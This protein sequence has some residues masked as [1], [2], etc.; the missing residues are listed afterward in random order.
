MASLYGF[1]FKHYPTSKALYHRFLRIVGHGDE[2]L[3]VFNN[4]TFYT[5][6]IE[7]DELADEEHGSTSFLLGDIYVAEQEELTVYDLFKRPGLNIGGQLY[8][9][10]NAYICEFY[11]V[12]IFNTRE[13]PDEPTHFKLYNEYF[14]LDFS[15]DGTPRRVDR[16]SLDYVP[17]QDEFRLGNHNLK[18]M[19]TGVRPYKDINYMFLIETDDLK[20]AAFNPIDSFSGKHTH[21]T[22]FANQF[23][24][25]IQYSPKKGAYKDQVLD[26]EFGGNKVDRNRMRLDHMM[27]AKLLWV[28]AQNPVNFDLF[29]I[30]VHSGQ[31]A[32]PL[33]RVRLG[34]FTFRDKNATEW[35]VPIT[36]DELL[37]CHTWDAKEI[38]GEARGIFYERKSKVFY[39]FIKRFYLRYDKDMVKG[40]FFLGNYDTDQFYFKEERYFGERAHDV[41]FE[42][43]VTNVKWDLGRARM[44]VKNFADSTY[45]TPAISN[46]AITA[47]QKGALAF[48]RIADGA[49]DELSNIRYCFRQTLE[50]DGHIYCFDEKHYRLIHKPGKKLEPR[51]IARTMIGS[52]FDTAPFDWEDWPVKFIFNYKED[53]VVFLSYKV[54]FVFT[55][56]NFRRMPDDTLYFADDRDHVTL[57]AEHCLFREYSIGVCSDGVE[58]KP[59][60]RRATKKVRLSDGK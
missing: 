44:Y 16:S 55:Y 3:F 30:E 24:L 50:V 4:R 34:Y 28:D 43:G 29:L 42:S 11:R 18:Q 54:Q 31:V 20:V 52:I 38:R 13:N 19:L 35:S 6:R 25:V 32:Y 15:R 58:L 7:I 2:I 1:N 41:K 49:I 51:K 5:Q 21:D 23:L 36:M 46:F 8:N 45:L 47:D 17:P 12:N 57:M 9:S 27:F 59:I 26:E 37:S 56:R 48:K 10:K 39:I 40:G 53:L 22:E 33:I 14:H 60:E